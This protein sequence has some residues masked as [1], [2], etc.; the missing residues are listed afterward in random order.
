MCLYDGGKSYCTLGVVQSGPVRTLRHNANGTVTDGPTLTATTLYLRTAVDKTGLSTFHYSLDGTTFAQLGTAYQLTWGNYRGTSIGIFGY[1]NLTD[2][3]RLDV[4]WFHYD[5]A[6][7]TQPPTNPYATVQAETYSGQAGTQLENCSEGGKDV[8]FISNND[9]TNYRNIDFGSSGASTFLARV[10]S[11]TTGGT[12]EVR[13]DSPTGPLAGT[14][15]VTNTG[16]WQTYT[17]VTCP[18]TGVTGTRWLYLIYKGAA[19]T[20]STST[21]SASV[22]VPSPATPSTAMPPTPPATAGQPPSTAVSP[23]S[24]ARRARPS[25]CPATASTSACPPA[26]SQV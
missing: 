9:H 6:G 5:Y 22:P 13:L 1:N 2:T 8:C 20:C 12:I 19:A 18:V 11:N 23:S 14:A 25:T 4:D 17:T 21:G 7:P 16:G 24:P 15:T 10:A 26:S 3:G